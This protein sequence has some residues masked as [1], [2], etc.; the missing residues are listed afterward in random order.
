MDQIILISQVR[1]IVEE[2]PP[3]TPKQKMG[4][5][6]KISPAPIYECSECGQDVL[7]SDI[8]AYRYCHGCGAKMG[9]S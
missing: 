3:V 5:W 6:V 8:D 4:H 9:E 2:M 7:T 1:K